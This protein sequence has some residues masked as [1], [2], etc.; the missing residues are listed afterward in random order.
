MKNQMI[1][2]AAVSI[3]SAIAQDFYGRELLGRIADRSVTVNVAPVQAAELYLEYGVTRGAYTSRTSTVTTAAATPVHIGIDKL[4]PDTQYYYRLRYRNAGTSAAF[5]QGEERSFHTQRPRG[6]TFTFAL[7]FDPHM[8]E[9]SDADVYRTTLR[10]QLAAKPDFM[11]DLGD[12]TMSDKLQPITESAIVDRFRLMRSFYD[13]SSHS[14]PLFLALGNHEGEWGR[15]LTANG[16]NVAVWNTIHRKKY[17]PNPVPDSFFSG[18][19]KVEPLVG[20][21]EAWYAFEW[22]DALFVILDP[23]WNR[24]VAPEASGDWSLTLG[25]TQYDW[26]KQ[27]LEN[28]SAKFKFVFAH[29]LIGGRDMNGPMRGGI[30]TAKYL[31]WGG[32]SMDDTWGFDRARPG[33]PM[34]IHQL[35]VANKVTAFFHGHDHLY[36]K[37]DLD[38]VVYQEGPQPSARN[39][40]L[41]N[42]AID[43]SYTSGT[44]LGG[45]GYIKVT[46]S[47]EQVK[48]EYVQTWLPSQET[49]ARKNG[50]IADTWT[51]AAPQERTATIVHAATREENGAI[52]ADSLVSA[53]VAGSAF[54]SATAQ[55]KLTDKSGVIRDCT[56]VRVDGPWVDF[57]VPPDTALG[58]AAFRLR[59]ADGSYALG[60][61]EITE[62]APGLFSADLTGTGWADGIAIYEDGSEQPLAIWEADANHYRPQP[63]D[64]ARSP[65]LRLRATG[66]RNSGMGRLTARLGDAGISVLAIEKGAAAGE[67]WIVLGPLQGSVNLDL[68]DLEL[69]AGGVMSNRVRIAIVRK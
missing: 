52:A 2:F 18:D 47:P 69:T 30:E 34:P 3:V 44:V 20:Q 64:A 15:N 16:A 28:S 29:N 67:D 4:E 12:T 17:F 27:T 53:Y 6:S 36:A 66:I 62:V 7:Q 48:A 68:A 46:V 45:T 43:Y 42:R 54:D 31:E 14:V 11:I 63:V 25:R 9:N 40:N 39:V 60:S 58:A 24:P 65:R 23:Y 61:A 10:N 51:V 22:G 41:G 50:M 55:V 26:L 13:V 59:M 8:D 49:A 21:R 56:I 37:Q 38:G 33:W 32:Y 1:L 35:L 57:S 19:P 5:A